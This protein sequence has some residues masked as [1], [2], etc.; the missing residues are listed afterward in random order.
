MQQNT[1][2]DS[3][4]ASAD[5]GDAS[6]DAHSGVPRPSEPEPSAGSCWPWLLL[7]QA[8]AAAGI[9]WLACLLSGR[10]D[11]GYL[12]LGNL[13]AWCASV[14]GSFVSL[15]ATLCFARSRCGHVGCLLAIVHAFCLLT[16]LGLGA[17]FLLTPSDSP[18]RPGGGF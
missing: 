17:L 7:A 13:V 8:P 12:G 11:P 16:L 15:V 10:A 4:S 3:A 14:G 1:P 5:S 9:V 18:P 6:V 2:S